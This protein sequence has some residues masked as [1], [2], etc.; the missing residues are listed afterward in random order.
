VGYDPLANKT[1]IRV[2]SADLF[3]AIDAEY[4]RAGCPVVGT[5]NLDTGNSKC[6]WPSAITLS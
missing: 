6:S 5:Y 2:V 3:S 4:N 1:I